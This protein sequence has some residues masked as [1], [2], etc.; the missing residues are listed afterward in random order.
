MQRPL[1]AGFQSL[2]LRGGCRSSAR[3]EYNVVWRCE[4][5]AG[6]LE[7]NTARR[8]ME[9]KYMF[10]PARSVCEGWTHPVMS[11]EV[12]WVEDIVD[13]CGRVKDRRLELGHLLYRQVVHMWR[14]SIIAKLLLLTNIRTTRTGGRPDSSGA[15][16]FFVSS[17]R[18]S[19]CRWSTSARRRM[20]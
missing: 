17:C 2:Q 16:R 13:E 15:R 18:I 3:R 1:R 4:E 8:A 9:P 14:R 5:L 12:V 11:Q 20:L 7:P 6:E 10:G 19:R